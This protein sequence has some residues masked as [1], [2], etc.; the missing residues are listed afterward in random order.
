V[1]RGHLA[2][3]PD[4]LNLLGFLT[5]VG[6]LV[7]LTRALPDR[8][9]R[10]SWCVPQA[11]LGAGAWRPTLHVTPDLAEAEIVRTLH[12]ELTRP[13]TIAAVQGLEPNLHVSG[14]VLRERATAFWEG[15]GDRRAADLLTALLGDG[16]REE[17]VRRSPLQVLT[18]AGQMR[19]LETLEFLCDP[20]QLQPEHVARALFEPWT[21][22]DTRFTFRWDPVDFRSWALRAR[23]PS[24]D[25]IHPVRTEWGANR[26]GFEALALFPITGSGE[27]VGFRHAELR[28]PL[29]RPPAGV[30]VIRSLLAHPALFRSDGA[31]DLRPLGVAAVVAAR[32]FSGAKGHRYFTAGRIAW[33]DADAPPIAGEP[34]PK[35][36]P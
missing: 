10:L 8:R 30:D 22:Q 11:G 29:W 19:F 32:R 23:N 31:G 13:D 6:A 15:R 35:P 12:A 24:G 20:E 4:G 25:E 27:T 3:G 26:L 21:Y 14:A 16:G 33:G 2:V 1:S 7:V 18:G 17:E 9:V 28:W 34:S 36:L 5:A